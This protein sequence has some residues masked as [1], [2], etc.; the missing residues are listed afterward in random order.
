[1]KKFT[2]L[3]ILIVSTLQ[4]YS[5]NGGWSWSHPTPQ[6]QIVR[7]IKMLD[8]NN[9]FGMCE[10]GVLIKTTN[11]GANWTSMY[12]GYQS[13]LYPGAGILQP[14]YSGWFF[15]ANN[16]ILGPQSARGI[17]RTTN[18]GNTYDTTQLSTSTGTIYDF[19]FINAQTGYL[20]ATSTFKVMKT[21]NAGVNWTTV[22]NLGSFTFYSVYASDTNNIITTSSSGNVY[23]TT[24]AGV[25]WTTSNVGT[26]A[27]LM[28]SKWSNM[29]TGYV[30]GTSGCFRYTTN[31][32]ANWSGTNPPTATSFNRLVFIGTDIVLAGPSDFVWKS[33]DNGTTW[34]SYSHVVPGQVSTTTMFSADATGS[35]I[36]IGGNYG[37]MN[38][39]TNG[40]ANWIAASAHS[41]A[42]FMADV[43]ASGNRIIAL[44]YLLGTAENIIYST[45]AGATWNP[46]A[47]DFSNSNL[48]DINM[49]NATTGYVVGR[50]GI[51]WK[52]TDG[53]AT[54]DT[55]K[56][57]NP[58]FSTY[59]CNGV[60][61]IDDN[62][63]FIS[64]GLAGVGGNTKIWRTT[65]AGSNWAEV[66]Q[67]YLAGPIA[68]KIDMV[69]ATTGYEAG[70]NHVQKTT[71]GGLNW[72]FVHTGLNTS[73]GYNGLC[74]V[75]ANNVF[76]SNT[77]SQVFG[78]SDGG[79]NWTNLNFPL[80][81]IGTLFC[82]DWVNA[83]TGMVA[84]VFGTVGKTTNRGASWE[85]SYNGG[86]TT[87]GIDMVNS[88]TAYAVCGNIA[89]GQILKY[90]KGPLTGTIN[91][92]NEIPKEY[93][94]GQN[95]PNPFNPS[96]TIKFALPKEG[97]VT[98]KIYDAAGREAKT[99]IN[100]MSIRSGVVTYSF[101]GSEL[102][103]GVYFYSLFV[104]GSRIDT[105]K[106]VLV[107]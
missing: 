79:A 83:N 38:K 71:D 51:F 57:L 53:G 43:Y 42:A 33:T 21:T 99:L 47:G 13:S 92:N 7:N 20:S 14:N 9:W 30:T 25:N 18:G 31:G 59:F 56:S 70:T 62:T 36:L 84:G 68:V 1:M 78:T 61:F 27:T 17:V 2:F 48:N 87:M 41:T 69:N 95:Y 75:D 37:I 3:L 11:A 74:V 91:W 81:G 80:T 10:Y 96:T 44:G 58:M 66:N 63:G 35:T 98:L 107:K 105:K 101:D 34:T 24:N 60:D 64:G 15:D 6:G 93:S 19:H 32:G 88:D 97:I 103:S 52:T 12:I 23:I 72:S 106:M 46:A 39:S 16:F 8:A 90:A 100:S 54:W 45:N 82:T 76:V 4:S 86:Y 65:D 85:I 26:T 89:G 55:T 28:D 67:S 40:G 5:Q 104:D 50:F 77:A 94:L 73:S 22:P 102:S 49:R 29:S